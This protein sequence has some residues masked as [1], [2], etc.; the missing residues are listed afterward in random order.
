MSMTRSSCGHMDGTGQLEQFHKHLNKQHPQIQFTREEENNN[1]ISF[2]DIL[3]KRYKERFTMMV[4][5]K[6]TNTDR[7][8]QFFSHHHLCVKSGTIRCLAERARRIFDNEGIKE[9][10]AHLRN[11]FRKNRYPQYLITQT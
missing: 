10:M 1:K 4:Y 6:P 11:V 5:R 7:Y 3:V 2:L 8:I 9:E